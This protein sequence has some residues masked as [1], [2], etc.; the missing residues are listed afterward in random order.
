MTE[1]ITA[2]AHFQV[3]QAVQD[4]GEAF[5]STLQLQPVLE[6][7]VFAAMQL[8]QGD[9]GSIMLLSDDADWLIVKAAI[10][11]H[12]DVILGQRQPA[13]ASIAGQ[14]LLHNQPILLKGRAEGQEGPS[15]AH[16]REI[17]RSVVVRLAVTGKSR[18]VLSVNTLSHRG[19]LSPEIIQLFRTLANQ[20][21][22]MIEHARLYEDLQQKE[23]RLERFVDRFLRQAEQRRSS[24]DLTETKLQEML[25][26]VVAESALVAPKPPVEEPNP[27]LQRLTQRE[28]EVLSYIVQGLTNKEIA[29]HLFLSPDTVKNHVVHIMEKLGAQDRTQAAVYAIRNGLVK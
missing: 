18:G 13:N 9:A 3:L 10:G 6:R 24:F 29:T 26:K 11:P 1:Q 2:D 5:A 27:M 22:I 21:A 14:A 8:V 25:S 12:S 19:E 23:Q 4:I 15:S 16:P 20:A 7:I 28:Q 17:D